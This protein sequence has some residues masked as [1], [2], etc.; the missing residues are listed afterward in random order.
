MLDNGII[1]D[2]VLLAENGCIVDYGE[3]GTLHVPEDAEFIDAG[4]DYVGPGFIDIHVHGGNGAMFDTDPHAACE[5]FLSCGETTIL[6]TL[7]YNLDREEMI[8]A[9]DRI[10]DV[11]NNTEAGKAIAGIYMEGPYMNPGHG[12]SPEKNKW[13][14]DVLKRDYK[15]IVD[16]GGDM[17]K[18]W[19]IAPERAGLEPFMRYARQVNP[20]VV[21]SVGHSEATPDEIKAL[22]GYGITLQ[23][24]CMNATGRRNETSGVRGAGPDEYCLLDDEMYA[25]LICDSRG[26]HV[27]PDLLRL[28]LKI[29]GVDKV[30][31]ISDSFVGITEPP[32]ELRHI[33]D[34]SFDANGG[35]CGSK[36]TMGMACKNMVAHTS[37]DMTEAFRMASL[38][39][40]KV[41]RIDG[42]TGSI[43]KGKKANLVI[44]DDTF[45]VKKV[46]LNGQTWRG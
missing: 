40:A 25:E 3:S 1:Q 13:R 33:S 19:A 31:L 39:P 34:L 43:K 27:C 29:K 38:N 42:E 18:V 6:P 26:I 17:V 23:T 14:G 7:F 32:E 28:V 21:F 15:A 22:G 5:Y 12:A 46:L 8:R 11:A 24:H 20:N 35:L 16:C 4:C 45:A 41:L 2:G 30:V 36:L 44:V 37:C 9:I 10:R